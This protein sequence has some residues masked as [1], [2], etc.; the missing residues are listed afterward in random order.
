MS[1]I[2]LPNLSN[3]QTPMQTPTDATQA[4][5]T[6]T[7]N[8]NKRSLDAEDSTVSNKKQE[9]TATRSIAPRFIAGRYN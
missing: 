1:T 4:G 8:A 2:V 5:Y 7:T 6:P 3:E 9:T